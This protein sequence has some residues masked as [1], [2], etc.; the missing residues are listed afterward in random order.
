MSCSRNLNGELTQQQE[1][2]SPLRRVTSPLFEHTPEGPVRSDGMLERVTSQV[3]EA[4]GGR[5]CQPSGGCVHTVYFPYTQNSFMRRIAECAYR[6][7]LLY[8][9]GRNPWATTPARHLRV[10]RGCAAD[11]RP[12]GGHVVIHRRLVVHV[13]CIRRAPRRQQ[14]HF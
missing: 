11:L 14:R 4:P 3:P 1:E 8:L 5:L 6:R 10:L 13:R 2:N 9:H 7:G 12:N